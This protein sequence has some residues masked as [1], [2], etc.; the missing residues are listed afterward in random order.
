M[1]SEKI[2]YSTREFEERLKRKPKETCVLRLYVTGMT[3]RSTRAI[4]NIK[5]LCEDHLKGRYDL[6]VIDIYQQPTLAAGD[7]IIA[8]P[9]LIK[10]LPLPLRKFIGDMV[11]QEKIILGLDLRGKKKRE[12]VP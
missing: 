5:K 3:P 2:T 1:K 8:A 11:N 6:E 4:Q 12:R 9:T 10:K 7:Q